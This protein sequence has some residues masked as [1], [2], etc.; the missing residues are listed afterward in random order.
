M[1]GNG[2]TWEYKASNDRQWQNMAS[3]GKQ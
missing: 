2:M 1:A 3:D